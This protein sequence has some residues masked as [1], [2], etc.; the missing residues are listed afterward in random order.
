MERYIP[1]MTRHNVN[2][3]LKEEP[4]SPGAR[5]LDG[6]P[7]EH[8]VVTRSLITQ[9]GE[10]E[11]LGTPRHAAP[12]SL[13]RRRLS[14]LHGLPRTLV[15]ETPEEAITEANREFEDAVGRSLELPIEVL[16]QQRDQALT[17]QV[18]SSQAL[19]KV[20]RALTTVREESARQNATLRRQLQLAWE[21]LE[22]LRQA[23]AQDDRAAP[24]AHAEELRAALA[25]AQREVEETRAEAARLQDE[26]D[27]A[28]RETDDVRFE[29]YSQVETARDETI[30]LQAQVDELQRVLTDT[31][32][33]ATTTVARLEAELE[34]ARRQ[35]QWQEV[36]MAQ[37][38]ARLAG[39]P[40]AP[41][42]AVRPDAAHRRTDAT[43]PGWRRPVN[44]RH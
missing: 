21:E 9:R 6:A 22:R 30:E 3:A 11:A 41:A 13:G 18:E 27:E 7:T 20:S 44:P 43:A 14:T 29:L 24:S 25:E 8:V 10:N 15:A 36:E 39:K 2:A 1:Q 32:D 5:A 35:L 38:K 16:I 12:P 42:P 28:I 33:E 19:H 37:L 23:A 31:R 17:Y 34:E 4:S 26:R 40:E